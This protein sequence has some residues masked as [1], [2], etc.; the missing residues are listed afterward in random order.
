MAIKKYVPPKRTIV[1]RRSDDGGYYEAECDNCGSSFY[2]K[3]SNA[4]YCCNA[5]S[6]AAHRRKQIELGILPKKKDVKAKEEQPA[7]A[8]PEVKPVTPE[9][10]PAEPEVK[11]VIVEE[12]KPVKA[13][14]AKEPTSVPRETAKQ[15]K[16]APNKPIQQ[17]LKPVVIPQPQPDKLL[18]QLEAKLKDLQEDLRGHMF[19][20]MKVSAESEIR[21]IEKKILQRKE[22]LT[23]M[24][25]AQ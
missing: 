16:K 14:K 24:Q 2:P 4:K 25:K 1:D 22:E 19:P 8:I 13:V 11:P 23:R 12:K 15:P 18:Q 7:A 20:I 3:R 10:K 21:H 5:C 6:V 9:P 17:V